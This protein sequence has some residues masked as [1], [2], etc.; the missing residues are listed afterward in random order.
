MK[1][2]PLAGALAAVFLLAGPSQAEET[3]K[4]RLPYR[5]LY[6]IQ[7]L[8]LELR[9][10]H[11]NLEAVLSMQST[12][13]NVK[14]GDLN[15]YIDA[16]DGKI[17]VTIGPAGDFAIPMSDNLLAQNPWLLVNQPRG[18]MRLDWQAGF[19]GMILT[20]NSIHYAE[21]MHPVRECDEL[22]EQV[23]R[24]FPGLAKEVMASGL[25]LVFPAQPAKALV[26]IHSRAGDRKLTA[27][28]KNEIILPL[29]A[30]LM[31]EDPFVSLSGIPDKMEI[32]SHKTQD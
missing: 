16:R 17:P 11:T 29:A 5:Q 1:V 27:N 14:S 6:E 8:E 22:K 18:T 15:V 31:E 20:T 30:D 26:V 3:E 4:A 23:R 13:T 28:E 24:I 12:R 32:A 25:K 7:K 9:Q 21:L 19:T 2:N 10:S